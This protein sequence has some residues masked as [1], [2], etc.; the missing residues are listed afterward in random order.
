MMEY[1]CVYYY[2]FYPERKSRD[3]KKYR[4]RQAGETA[5]PGD[6]QPKTSRVT[7]LN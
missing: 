6:Q 5:N 3:Y 1:K 7:K 2:Y 4:K